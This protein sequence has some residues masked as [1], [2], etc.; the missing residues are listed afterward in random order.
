MTVRRVSIIRDN[1]PQI[2]ASITALVGKQVLVGVPDRTANR[3]EEHDGPVT[4]A[5]LAYIHEHGSPDANIPARPFLVPGVQSAEPDAL[6]YLRLAAE[7]T[8]RGDTRRADAYLNDAGIVGM[9]GARRMIS[10]GDFVPLSPAT[11][12]NRHRS[13]GTQSRRASEDRYL[14]LYA[15]GMSPAEAQAATGIRP[16]N[17]T[18]Q[19][20]NAITYVLRTR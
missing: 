18:G 3:D 8:M 1:V 13:R 5:M 17:N 20:R 11:V 9:N 7:A 4:N 15:G 19:L 12:R 10:Y 6:R 14:E 2:V 16:L